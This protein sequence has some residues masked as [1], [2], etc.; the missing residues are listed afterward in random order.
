MSDLA[1]FDDERNQAVTS[2]A[3]VQ[4]YA[5]FSERQ[6]KFFLRIHRR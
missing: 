4:L 3:E 6:G 1:E 2:V 5:S